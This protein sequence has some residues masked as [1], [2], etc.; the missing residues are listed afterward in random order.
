MRIRLHAF[1]P[2]AL[3][4]AFLFLEGVA[5]AQRDYP[6]AIEDH[7]SL[8]YAPPC[9]VCHAKGNTGNG[10]VVTPFGWSLRGKGAVANDERSVRD[11]LDSMKSEHT[12]SDGD[13]VS[14]VDELV[15]GTDPNSPGAVKIPNGKEAGYGCGGTA[16]DPNRS[17][18]AFLFPLPFALGLVAK[19]RRRGT[20]RRER[21]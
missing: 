3:G 21:G 9:S 12:D 13:G 1:A 15:L 19:L 18:G 17:F 5:S 7:L 14:D 10:T 16:P 4:A 20:R 11:A 2:V 6:L 8:S